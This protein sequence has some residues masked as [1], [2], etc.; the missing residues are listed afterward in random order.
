MTKQ[1]GKLYGRDFFSLVSVLKPGHHNAGTQ[2]QRNAETH[3]DTADARR[4][5]VGKLWPFFIR[6]PKI[7]KQGGKLYGRDFFSCLCFKTRTP[8]KVPRELSTGLQTHTGTDRHAGTQRH[9]K[10]FT[11]SHSRLSIRRRERTQRQQQH[12]HQRELEPRRRHSRAKWPYSP[13]S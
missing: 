9:G 4:Q 12:K 7:L 10:T 11:K 5:R 13:H 2:R 8:Q 6:T 3:K 1:G